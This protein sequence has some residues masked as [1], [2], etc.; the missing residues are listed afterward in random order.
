MGEGQEKAFFRKVPSP[1]PN[2]ILSPQG[3]HNGRQ[4]VS[5]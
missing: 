3:F 1:F 4:A 5:V 2:P